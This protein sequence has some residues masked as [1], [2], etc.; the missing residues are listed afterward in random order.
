[1]KGGT[2]C[3]PCEIK[4]LEK[5]ENLTCG[6]VVMERHQTW[7]PVIR[8][9]GQRGKWSVRLSNCGSNHSWPFF[10]HCPK[11]C[12]RQYSP[13]ICLHMRAIMQLVLTKTVHLGLH[14]REHCDPTDCSLRCRFPEEEGNGPNELLGMTWPV[15]SRSYQELSEHR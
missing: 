13:Q 11:I 15:I 3:L 12:S 14:A 2:S 9:C 5:T 1:M 6:A 7:L 4:R 8:L 10:Q